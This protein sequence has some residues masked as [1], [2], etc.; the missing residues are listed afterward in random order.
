[1][2]SV[3]L[4]LLPMLKALSYICAAKMSQGFIGKATV[5]IQLA[6]MD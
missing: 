6:M 3:L 4:D 2:K 1:L 5:T